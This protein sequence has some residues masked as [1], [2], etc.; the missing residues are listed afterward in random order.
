MK[1]T[2]KWFNSNKGYGFIIDP[3]SEKDIFVHFSEIEINT[4]GFKTLDDGEK[5][6]FELRHT[7]KGPQA[8]NV[9][10]LGAGEE[11]AQSAA[12]A[13]HKDSVR[14]E[15]RRP[16]LVMPRTHEDGDQ[17]VD[18][19]ADNKSSNPHLILFKGGGGMY[20]GDGFFG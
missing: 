7:P 3:E 14:I 4:K 11:K 2:V 5:V 17:C 1:G 6:E 18:E 9:R 10:K 16:S 15:S 12:E 19:D 13:A 20:S 8:F